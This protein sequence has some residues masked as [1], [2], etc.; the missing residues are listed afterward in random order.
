MKQDGGWMGTSKQEDMG[1][2]RPGSFLLCTKYN[3]VRASLN[4]FTIKIVKL[5]SAGCTFNKADL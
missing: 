1:D 2:S 5:G 4:F 3:V